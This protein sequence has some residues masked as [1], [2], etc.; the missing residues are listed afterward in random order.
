MKLAIFGS[1]GKVGRQVMAQAAEKGHDVTAHARSPEKLEHLHANVVV[2]KGDV[3][4]YDS[5]LKTVQGQDAVVCALGMPLLNKDGLRTNG[6]R[7]II[8]AM[9]DTGAKRLICLS[10]LGAGDSFQKLP[11]FYRY[12]VFP[13]ILRHVFADHETQE[14]LVRNSRLDWTIARPGNFRD[15]DLT[16]TYQHGFSDIDKSLKLKISYADVADF[17]LK[18]LGDDTYLH[19]APGLSY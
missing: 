1:T 19:Q 3:L 11:L 14:A 2:A 18:Q 9:E 10:G 16:G 6:T 8:R 4:D 17:M 5:V 15:G 7:N 12:F 13:V